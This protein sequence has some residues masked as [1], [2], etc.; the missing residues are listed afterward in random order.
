MV[1]T[2]SSRVLVCV[3]EAA[4]F[5]NLRFKL[6]AI[7]LTHFGHDPCISVQ[8]LSNA[9]VLSSAQRGYENKSWRFDPGRTHLI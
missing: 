3:A 4:N 5:G 2:S 9:S 7:Y 8:M 1:V 6:F